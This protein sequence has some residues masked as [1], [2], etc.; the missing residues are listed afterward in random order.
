MDGVRR[1]VTVSGQ[2]L[3]NEEGTLAQFVGVLHDVTES[4]R[5]RSMA[6]DRALFAE[7]MVGIVSHDLRN[8]L[9]AIMAGTA[10]WHCRTSRRKLGPSHRRTSSVPP[11]ARVG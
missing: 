6:L 8:P 3:L 9:S 7:Q 5:D 10:V 4:V 11:S 1:F 2:A